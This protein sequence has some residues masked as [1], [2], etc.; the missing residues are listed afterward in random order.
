MTLETFAGTVASRVSPPESAEAISAEARRI[1]R[2][3]S[4]STQLVAAAVL[5]IAGLV[6]QV[7][8]IATEVAKLIK[9]FRERD[10]HD[11]LMAVLGRL[12][13]R[14]GDPATKDDERVKEV[15]AAAIDVMNDGKTT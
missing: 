12:A 5:L 11:Q 1:A 3:E 2:G 13:E 7:C 14:T 4:G 10:R 9:G 15:T 6:V 8:T